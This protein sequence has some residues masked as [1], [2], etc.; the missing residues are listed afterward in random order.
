MKLNQSEL[1]NVELL[2]NL[3]EDKES[4]IELNKRIE[5]KLFN[6]T[7]ENI[8]SIYLYLYAC[9]KYE[10]YFVL[11]KLINNDKFLNLL[12]KSE[13][14]GSMIVSLT[15]AFADNRT[16]VL[17]LSKVKDSIINGDELLNSE[18]VLDDITVNE[19]K[20]L[21]KDIDIDN[22]LITNGLRFDALTDD[23][24]KKLLSDYSLL[25]IY[26]N[27]VIV[28]FTN[29]L[30]NDLIKVAN[31]QDYLDVYIKQLDNNYCTEDRIFNYLTIDNLNYLLSKNL[32]PEVIYHLV[33]STIGNTKEELLKNERVLELVKV[34]KDE[35]V[36][37]S[38]PDNIKELV[39]E[40]KKNI[41]EG[42]YSD[43]LYTLPKKEISRL[44]NINLYNEFI[45]AL[46]DGR[47]INYK[48]LVH[49]LPS[50]L[51][52]DLSDNKLIELDNRTLC[53][54]IKIN[55]ILFKKSILNNKD[56]CLHIASLLPKKNNEL[57]KEIFVVGDFT[58]DEQQIFVN[59][60]SSSRSSEVLLSLIDTV[61]VNYRKNIYENNSIMNK[62]ISSSNFILDEYTTSYLLGNHDEVL[63]LNDDVLVDLL[64]KI[65][66]VEAQ[67]L[68]DDNKV[69]EKLFIE[70]KDDIAGLINRINK[71]E[72]IPYFTK[73][74]LIKYY[75]KE[76]LQNILDVLPLKDKKAIFVPSLQKLIFKDE[77]LVKL[78]RA[79][80]NKNSYV[81]DTIY[82]NFFD[83]T[84]KGIKLN[85]LDMITKNRELQENLYQINKKTPYKL[86]NLITAFN[87]CEGLAI[88]EIVELSNIYK[89]VTIGN[90][91]K[92]YGNIPKIL[93]V[94]DKPNLKAVVSYMLY[95]IPRY[96]AHKEMVGRPI[97]VDTPNTYNDIITY[98]KRLEE[99]ATLNIN[100][101]KKVLENFIIK[102]FKLTLEEAT[103][104]T[105]RYNIEKLDANVYK[106][107]YDYLSNLNMIINTDNESL[108]ELD[109]KYPIYTMFDSFLMENQIKEMY[110]KIYNF[111]IKTRSNFNKY[112]IEKLYGKEIKIS[113]C[114]N[115]FMFLISEL[116]ITEELRK[117]NSYLEAWHYSLAKEKMLKATLISNENVR[118]SNDFYF[119]FNGVLDNGI[120]K[121]SEKDIC[122]ECCCSSKIS[123]YTPFEMINRTRYVNTIFL[124]KYAVRPNYN[125]S[126][127]PYIEPDFIIVN[128]ARLSDHTYL[129]KVIRA[130]EEFKTKRNK[131]GL[132][133][134][135]IDFNTLVN[136]EKTKIEKTIAKYEK[137]KDM[138][139]INNI[140]IRVENNYSSYVGS[141]YGKE[142][143]INIVTDLVKKRI[144]KSNSVAELQYLLDVF[145]YESNKFNKGESNIKLDQLELLIKN[146]I[147]EINS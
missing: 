48:L 45:E 57:L 38:L 16:K 62:I 32:K 21:R 20:E 106:K 27:K 120:V 103:I 76:N 40:D 83:K 136:N 133:I 132:P 123:Y 65:N 94:V 70:N 115:E 107:E 35:F 141:E 3:K 9:N 89:D 49:S 82:L 6:F 79:L 142:F 74:S 33:R 66:L 116:D 130:S 93:S 2:N 131:N 98:E 118:P 102:H 146:R 68:L 26:S 37:A 87:A 84:I 39:L 140:L 56:V 12:N 100:K 97:I 69:L 108:K 64:N 77:E 1:L 104:M 126:N 7:E 96:Y 10:E 86:N 71:K 122:N 105:D 4:L 43:I 138:S 24:K 30:G 44:F 5:R 23:T 11:E 91:R 60:C 17:A 124:D 72:L 34:C 29:S 13:I 59:N 127:L 121:M 25:T 145:K 134:Y 101:G 8:D 75:N 19:L 143:K 95:L 129:E 22:F 135:G 51:L 125:N 114:S 112:I 36:L 52:K 42:V 61:S 50:D 53:E 99:I 55:P 18:D 137:S 41:L 117:T 110:G 67:K 111:E 73:E 88:N 144:P 47:D 139:L 80:E 15:N 92:K 109:N 28:E 113:D 46:K 78:Y 31:D 85:L 58:P 63:E 90:N 119:G 54:L 14:S 81:V 128:M 147:E